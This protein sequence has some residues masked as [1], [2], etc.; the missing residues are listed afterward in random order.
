MSICVHSSFQPSVFRIE[1]AE[2]SYEEASRLVKYSGSC[3]QETTTV[4]RLSHEDSLYVG[5]VRISPD[6][7]RV[8]HIVAVVVFVEEPADLFADSGQVLQLE[9]RPADVARISWSRKRIS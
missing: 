3:L 7:R 2:L 5:P 4:C 9:L 6:L 1:P 8:R